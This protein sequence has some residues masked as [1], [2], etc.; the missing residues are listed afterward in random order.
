[1]FPESDL[2]E[3]VDEVEELAEDELVHVGGVRVQRPQE[4]VHELPPLR[5]ELLR[6]RVQHVLAAHPLKEQAQLAT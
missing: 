4:V 1:M 3:Y 2:E 6:R 5:R